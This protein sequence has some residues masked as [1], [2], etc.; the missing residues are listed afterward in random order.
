MDK[1]KISFASVNAESSYVRFLIIH[2]IKV[3]NRLHSIRE[4][5]AE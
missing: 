3:N 4:V 2:L 1:T 5:S